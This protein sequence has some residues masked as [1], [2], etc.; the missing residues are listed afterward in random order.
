MTL[1]LNDS[2]ELVA[3][4]R[5][6]MAAMF[7]AYMREPSNLGPLP[8]GS[9]FGPRAVE[10]QKEYELRT[11]QVPDG[12]VSDQDLLDLK[13]VKPHRPIWGY[14]APGSGVPW[15]IGPPFD[16]GEWCKNVLNLNHQPLGYDIGG[17]LGLMGGD[18]KNSYND[19]IAQ[20][21]AELEKQLDR[22]P[23]INN[24]DVEFWF[25][26]YSQSAEGMKKA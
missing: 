12:K 2:G 22:C 16:L 15:W 23:D 10:W 9:V 14:S 25:Y 13:I 3:R 6:V 4:W 17:Y 21:D 11:H 20:E 26:C 19:I 7:P 24:P 8:P 18:P 5:H 1:Q